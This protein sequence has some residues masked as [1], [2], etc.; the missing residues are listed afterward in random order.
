MAINNRIRNRK[1]QEK[2]EAKEAIIELTKNDLFISNINFDYDKYQIVEDDKKKLINFEKEMIFQG[3]KLGEVAYNIGKT[4]VEVKDVF[5]KY[6][7]EKGFMEWYNTIGLNKD[8]VYIYIGR[9]NLGLKNPEAKDRI[10]LLSDRTI[11]ETINKK[12][13][14]EIKEKVIKGELSTGK[15]VKDARVKAISSTLEMQEAEIVESAENLKKIEFLKE[16]DKKIQAFKFIIENQKRLKTIKNIIYDFEQEEMKHYESKKEFLELTNSD[17]LMLDA[18]LSFFNSSYKIG[19]MH[20]FDG[21]SKKDY[22]LLK[23]ALDIV[24]L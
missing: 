3:K 2:P 18:A 19:F 9:Y 5:N 4:L 17:R 16:R 11:K 8:Q 20:I 7:Q 10:L 21:I 14:E 13:P 15:E 12:T 23:E 6:Q 24:Y 1:K 22:I